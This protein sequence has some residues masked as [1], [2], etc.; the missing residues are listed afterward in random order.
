MDLADIRKKAG[1]KSKKVGAA[2][3]VVVQ[4]AA[5]SDGQIPLAQ[6][7]PTVFFAPEADVVG[8]DPLEALFSGTSLPNWSNEDDYLQGL[9]SAERQETADDCQWL[10]FALGDETYTLDI[11]CIREIIKPREITEI[12]RAPEFILGIISLRGVI[13]PIFDLKRRLKLGVSEIDPKS[14]IVVCQHGEREA[15]L[16][17]DAITEVVRMPGHKV[18][19]PPA[20]LSGIDRDLV[21][22]VGRLQGKLMILL[23]L[24]SVL[25]AQLV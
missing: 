7:L 25:D 10:A 1:R 12:P 16:L 3:P 8:I 19:P 24:P 13:I 18:E 15:G 14:R 20:V 11:A 6:A 17:V 22:G 5:E 9:L 4:S 23:H 2:P 21:K